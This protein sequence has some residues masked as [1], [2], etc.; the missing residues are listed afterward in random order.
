MQ[1]Y[2]SNVRHSVDNMKH[3]VGFLLIAVRLIAPNLLFVG[4]ILSAL[5]YYQTTMTGESPTWKN[6]A[7]GSMAIVGTLAGLGYRDFVSR[8]R[9]FE[10]KLEAD[11]L[12]FEKQLEDD[13]HKRDGQHKANVAAIVALAMATSTTLKEDDK[14]KV[15]EIIKKLLED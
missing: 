7:A 3:E 15:Q 4:M 13:S 14:D 6:V 11:R 10:T 1:R 12:A 5:A 8:I 2:V 9:K